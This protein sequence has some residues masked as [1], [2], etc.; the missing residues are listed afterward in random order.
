MILPNPVE[1]LTTKI[2]GSQYTIESQKDIH[3]KPSE[4]TVVAKGKDCT[5]YEPGARVL[6]G[7]FSG[8]E[9]LF[10]GTNY[11]ILAETEILGERLVTPFDEDAH[12]EQEEF[13]RLTSPPQAQT[14]DGLAS[15]L[16]YEQ[17]IRT[18]DRPGGVTSVTLRN[19]QTLKQAFD[20]S[21]ECVFCHELAT[22]ATHTC[23]KH[24]PTL[25]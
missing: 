13:D 21:V 16:A 11:L 7:K 15:R 22:T 18:F 14:P 12:P 6:Y 5:E 2:E 9:Q 19:G 20:E 25:Q 24:D 10:D 17:Q 3:A 4:G 23:A 8:Y 1:S